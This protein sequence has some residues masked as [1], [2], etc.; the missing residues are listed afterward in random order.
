MNGKN[1]W[2]EWRENVDDAL[3]E[4]A[5]RSAVED[6]VTKL[7]SLLAAPDKPKAFHSPHCVGFYHHEGESGGERAYALV[8]EIQ[9]QRQKGP[10][11][12]CVAPKVANCYF[13]EEELD[14][15]Q[16]VEMLVCSKQ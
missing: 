6:R 8:Y 16:R 13:V 12:R 4:Q 9:A 11:I 3:S 14:V 15:G 2:L 5:Y 7:A 1:V 10:P